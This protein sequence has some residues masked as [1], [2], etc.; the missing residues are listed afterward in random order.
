MENSHS[1][2][3]KMFIQAGVCAGKKRTRFRGEWNRARSSMAVDASVAWTNVRHG[4]N[5]RFSIGSRASED[6][7]D[8]NDSWNVKLSFFFFFFTDFELCKR[9][10]NSRNSERWIL[11]YHWSQS[12]KVRI[13][14]QRRAKK[15]RFLFKN[16]DIRSNL[17]FIFIRHRSFRDSFRFRYF[18]WFK[19][20]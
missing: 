6:A 4:D 10:R 8:R 17:L 3:G 15:N 9:L 12:N 19:Y 2:R 13:K 5:C 16:T 14:I 20:W 7:R 11:F 1:A 18:N